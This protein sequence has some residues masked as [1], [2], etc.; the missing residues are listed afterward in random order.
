MYKSIFHYFLIALS[1]LISFYLHAATPI[2]SI[3]ALYKAP[4][5]L[6]PNSFTAAV[7]QVTNNASTVSSF[8]LQPIPG[9]TQVTNLPGACQN[10]IVLTQN[11]SCLLNLRITGQGIAELTQS[12]PIICQNANRPIAC[13]QPSQTDSL[14]I[15]KT[16][17][18][19]TQNTWI[20]V[21]I[22]QDAPPNDI[23]TYMNQIISLAPALNQIHF[24]FPAG[25][26]NYSTY[27]DLVNLFRTAYG[28]NLL[29]GFHPDA[30]SSSYSDWGCSS[31]NWQCVLNQSI[32]AMNQIN[33]QADPQHT[34]NGLTIYSIEQSYVYPTTS[35][36]YRD[37]KACLNPPTV[38]PC[39][40]TICGTCP[41][42]VTI[43]TPP[44]VKYGS[45]LPSYGDCG[46]S[47]DCQ[48]GSD[49]LDYGYPQNYNLGKNLGGY[50]DLI[51]NGFFPSFTTT[52]VSAPFPN[53]LYVVDEDNGSSPYTPQI[54]CNS[55]ANAFVYANPTTGVTPD[56]GV[57]S[58]YVAYPMTQLP[59]ITNVPDTNGATVYLVFSGEGQP[60]YPSLF[61]GAPGWSLANILAFYQGINTNFTTLNNQYPAMFSGGVFDQGID[62]SLIQYGIWNFDSILANN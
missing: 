40:A 20:K 17:A 30:S 58:A 49:A 9:V 12:G 37:V 3:T 7:Y 6:A 31:G 8:V 42:G 38:T 32:I 23:A 55:P 1:S 45:V 11:Q 34:G 15:V 56:V 61:L 29:L 57:A 26:K 54:P 36:G 22:A 28:S 35:Q 39:P 4:T 10:P 62:P 2:V 41:T 53:P 5:Q 33:A 18:N 59:P 51:T 48:Y 21:L 52:C 14:R 16:T 27:S 13:S 43:A 60:D 46:G 44:Y 24:R 47:P 19:L 25:G 50:T